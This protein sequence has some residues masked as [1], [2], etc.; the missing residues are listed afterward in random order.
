ML[1]SIMILVLLASIHYLRSTLG[2]VNDIPY[3]VVNKCS[4]KMKSRDI[5][6]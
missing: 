4:K 5:S 6:K 2:I 3:S 1:F